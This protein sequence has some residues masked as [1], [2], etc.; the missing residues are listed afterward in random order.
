MKPLFD[1][2]IISLALN[3][4]LMVFKILVYIYLRSNSMLVEG[5]NSFISA[6]FAAVACISIEYSQAALYLDQIVSIVFGI[7]LLIY[8]AYNFLH[9]ISKTLALLIKNERSGYQRLV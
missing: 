5:V 7:F 4:L 2:A 3:L 1:L 6:L 9:T 8:G